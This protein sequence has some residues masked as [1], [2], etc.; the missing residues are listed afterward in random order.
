MKNKMPKR[1]P[2]N[3]IFGLTLV[4]GNVEIDFCGKNTLDF[5][6]SGSG[7]MRTRLMEVIGETLGVCLAQSGDSFGDLEGRLTALVGATLDSHNSYNNSNG[8][9]V[10]ETPVTWPYGKP[11]SSV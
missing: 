1:N 8:E 4:N 3:V 10:G 6:G 9:K 2:N 7:G 5:L 11:D